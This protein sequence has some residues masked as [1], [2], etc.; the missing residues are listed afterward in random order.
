MVHLKVNTPDSPLS[1]AFQRPVR[2]GPTRIKDSS[3]KNVKLSKT[4]RVYKGS[5]GG[6]EVAFV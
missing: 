5:D 2:H 1:T 3:L 6:G 4:R